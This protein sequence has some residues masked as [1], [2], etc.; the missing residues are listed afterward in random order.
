MAI[1]TIRHD[2]LFDVARANRTP[3]TIIGCGAIGSRI[4]ASLIELGITNII[5]IDADRVEAH[6]IANQAFSIADIGEHK[7]YA[8]RD[9]WARK[10]GQPADR[11]P[12]QCHNLFLTEASAN[13]VAGNVFLCVDS[14]AARRT[15]AG[16]LR[17]PNVFRVF[18]TRT[19]STHGN[20]LGFLP[21]VSGEFERWWASLGSDDPDH[22]ELSACGSAMSIGPTASIIANLAVWDYMNWIENPTAC[23]GR[24]DIFLKPFGARAA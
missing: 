12:T 16:L 22:S 10:M 24:V 7:V 2:Q 1:S 21:N 8:L 13:P 5:A 9:I 20:V 3:T 15:I 23:N 6:N 18:D 19:A 4:Y 17:A 14:F 11:C